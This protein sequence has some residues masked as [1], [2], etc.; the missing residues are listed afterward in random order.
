MTSFLGSIVADALNIAE[1]SSVGRIRVKEK[2]DMPVI[3]EVRIILCSKGYFFETN[4]LKGVIF[5]LFS[6]GI[7]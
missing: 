1:K 6:L 7:R 2:W 5:K 3:Y 4:I